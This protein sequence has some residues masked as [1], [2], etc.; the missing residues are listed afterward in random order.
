MTVADV[1][2]VHAIEAATFAIPW[3]QE[4]LLHEMEGNACARYLV[5][6]GGQGEVVG[7][8]GAWIIFDEG[9]ITNV[10][11]EAASRG[12]GIGRAL[13]RALM[14][15][16]SNLGVGYLTLEV[17]RGNRTA[18]ALYQSLGFVELSVRKRYYEDNGED[19][20]LMVC[21]HLPPADED[22]SEE[23]FEV[24][25]DGRGAYPTEPSQPEAKPDRT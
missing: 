14:G 2:E 10:A 20:L 8:A 22:F 18:Q 24:R 17:R 1:P 12:R 15:Y 9:H 19:A 3:S 21:D 5:A 11:V 7:Y 4:S 6:E 25:L 23:N 13:M 16:A